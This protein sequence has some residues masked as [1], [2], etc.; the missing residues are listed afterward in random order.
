MP[1]TDSRHRRPNNRRPV[2]RAEMLAPNRRFHM[3]RKLIESPDTS[4]MFD[5]IFELICGIEGVKGWPVLR[6]PESRHVTILSSG[7]IRRAD[8]T[9][10]DFRNS[11]TPDLKNELRHAL[12][13]SAGRNLGGLSVSGLVILGDERRSA[14]SHSVAAKL[15]CPEIIEEHKV[16]KDKIT[17]M[18]LIPFSSS[19]HPAHLTVTTA[20]GEF[21]QEYLDNV[22]RQANLQTPLISVERVSMPDC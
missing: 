4:A 16:A 15:V 10:S 19:Q 1:K 22:W 18:T 8:V 14:G 7:D 2:Q 21:N 5:S 11:A 9:S 13:T 12:P 3:V 17:Q 6:T 20:I